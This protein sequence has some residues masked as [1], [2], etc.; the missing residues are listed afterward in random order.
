[1]ILVGLTCQ[2][3]CKSDPVDSDIT[4][5]SAASFEALRS[6]FIDSK[7]Q[8]VNF[9][10]ES[11]VDFTS[12][13]GARVQIPSDCLNDANGR[14]VKGQ[15][16]LT[17][18]ELYDRGGMLLANKPLMGVN[19]QGQLLP[20]VTGGQYY[21]T[22]KQGEKDLRPGCSFHVQIPARHTGG[23]DQEMR[24]WKGLI[25]AEGNLNWLDIFDPKV[26]P[27]QGDEPRFEEGLGVIAGDTGQ[28]SAY[29][30][31]LSA[32]FGWTNVDRFV[33]VDGPK[34]KIQV[35]VPE[36]YDQRNSAVYLLYEDEPNAL[37]QL[38]IYDTKGKFFTEHYGFVPVG[39]K[40]HIVFASASGQK[41]VYSIKDVQVTN[42]AVYT[43]A[44]GDLKTMDKE[45]LVK[46]INSLK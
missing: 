3:S 2:V 33:M 14:P 6:D 7:A 35:Q 42:N 39:L 34:T 27:A 40:V 21:L 25:G 12:S 15:V 19:D 10:A 38:D 29:Y 16:S 45:N 9:P 13:M 23:I 30:D 17:F 20:L 8:G 46:M 24:L 5:A 1:M 32:Y 44:Q 26:N 41:V 4:K 31:I 37:A 18:V 22:V 11:G 28:Y 36:G 43:F